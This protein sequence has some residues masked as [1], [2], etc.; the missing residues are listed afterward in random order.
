M[1]APA[2]WFA[3]CKR[4]A[5]P[6]QA[7]CNTCDS[8]S[9]RQFDLWRPT[10]RWRSPRLE[11]VEVARTITGPPSAAWHQLP[12]QRTLQQKASAW[13]WLKWIVGSIAVVAIA[14]TFIWWPRPVPSTTRLIY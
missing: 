4:T 1:A 2:D 10:F 8:P 11:G 12:A 9:A 7:G 13:R 5:R 6:A 14:L 3:S